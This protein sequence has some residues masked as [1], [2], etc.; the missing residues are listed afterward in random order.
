MAKKAETQENEGQVEDNGAPV[1]R[2]PQTREVTKL[3]LPFPEPKKPNEKAAN[4]FIEHDGVY[5]H[6]EVIVTDD[7]EVFPATQKGENAATNYC[8]AKGIKQHK[9]SRY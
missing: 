2:N 1:Q 7:L 8:M 3:E 4:Y 6:D 9:F 5:P